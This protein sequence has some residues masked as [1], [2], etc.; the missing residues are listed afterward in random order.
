[1]LGKLIKY[2][3]MATG[4]IFLPLIAAFLLISLIV[5][6]F[7]RLNFPGLALISNLIVL[8]IATALCVVAF[9]V[10][11]QRFYSGLLGNEGYLMFTLPTS[12]D[13][14]ILS[15]LIVSVVWISTGFIAMQAFFVMLINS[16]AASNLL[17]LFD[18]YR[19]M[20]GSFPFAAIFSIQ[21]IFTGTL[22]LYAS[23]SIGMLAGQYRILASCGAY[24]AT[25]IAIPVTYS[26]FI[27]IERIINLPTLVLIDIKG[28]VFLDTAML[29]FIIIHL[30]ICLVLYGI[31]RYL[32][33]NR[34]NLE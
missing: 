10:T 34:L 21:L 17:S 30:I 4:R 1:M 5:G 2:E 7:I 20:S 9:I 11:L 33:K 6:I 27:E 29:E 12:V 8:F 22:M 19:W 25:W 28:Y 16:F 14:L 31:T 3:F 18:V 13:S 32:L 26:V 15:K 24:V 23:M